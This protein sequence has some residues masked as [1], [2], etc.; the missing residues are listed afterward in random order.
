MRT[1]NG[2]R[3]PLEYNCVDCGPKMVFRQLEIQG[4]NDPVLYCTGC[5]MV[6]TMRGKS[7]VLRGTEG[8]LHYLGKGEFEVRPRKKK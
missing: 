5:G 1:T 8:S 6:Y 3:M 7:V 2:V 4:V